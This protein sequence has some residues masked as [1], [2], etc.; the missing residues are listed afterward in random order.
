LDHKDSV[1]TVKAVPVT[2]PETLGNLERTEEIEEEEE[3]PPAARRK[4]GVE[5]G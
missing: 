5:G 1:E 3:R 4:G 2:T